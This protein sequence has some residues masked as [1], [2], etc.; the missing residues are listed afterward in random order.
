MAYSRD[1]FNR[2][3]RERIGRNQRET[4]KREERTI[5]RLQKDQQ[6]LRYGAMA[7]GL[8][9]TNKIA[10]ESQRDLERDLEG[11][12]ESKRELEKARGSKSELEGAREEIQSYLYNLF[13]DKRTNGRTLLVPK[14]AIATE[15]QRQKT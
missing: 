10:R 9:Q 6:E 12:R 13:T 7:D 3:T 5:D 15:K 11:A 2:E 14:V 8:S 1:A 4:R